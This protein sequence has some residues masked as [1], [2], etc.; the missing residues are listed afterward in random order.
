MFLKS[1]S[2]ITAFAA[3]A[4]AKIFYAGVAESSGEF[5]VWSA[6]S[7]KGFGLPGR[8]GIDYAFI[9][10]TGIDIHVDQNK[11]KPSMGE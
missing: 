2:A 11:V 6:T 9:D 5:G 8:F 7:Q 10:K 3:V 1:L 4:S